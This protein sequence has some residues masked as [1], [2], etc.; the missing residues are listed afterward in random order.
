MSAA[1]AEEAP[2]LPGGAAALDCGPLELLLL[3]LPVRCVFAALSLFIAARACCS[4]AIASVRVPWTVPLLEPKLQILTDHTSLELVVM[5]Y[6]S[7]C[8]FGSA[9]IVPNTSIL[10]KRHIFDIHNISQLFPYCGRRLR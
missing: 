2:P 1:V 9:D 10:H 3:P 6:N 8:I 5:L 7:A 4:A